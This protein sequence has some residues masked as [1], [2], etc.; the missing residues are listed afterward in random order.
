MHL[1]FRSDQEHRTSAML[2][3]LNLEF[4]KGSSSFLD[5]QRPQGKDTGT[6][7]KANV[8]ARLVRQ[9]L[10]AYAEAHRALRFRH[11]ACTKGLIVELCL[12]MMFATRA[13]AGREWACASG[14]PDDLVLIRKL[15]P[16]FLSL[17]R[18]LPACAS[19]C[20]QWRAWNGEG[21]IESKYPCMRPMFQ[22]SMFLL[23]SFV[24]PNAQVGCLR[25]SPSSFCARRLRKEGLCCR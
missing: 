16:R 13:G 24:M 20:R 11:R 10:G 9:R 12:W 21:P 3:R 6:T 8:H 17:C 15:A 25:Y 4:P 14:S 2:L 23:F 5:I 18:R 7:L 1:C 19:Y 22:H